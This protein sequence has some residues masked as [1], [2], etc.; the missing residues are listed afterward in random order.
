MALYRKIFIKIFI[1]CLN[2]KVQSATKNT[3]EAYLDAI[4]KSMNPFCRTILLD[5]TALLPVDCVVSFVKQVKNLVHENISSGE[6]RFALIALKDLA[7][8]EANTIF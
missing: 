3:N 6:L 4:E 8:K 1:F 7:L 2:L 5:V